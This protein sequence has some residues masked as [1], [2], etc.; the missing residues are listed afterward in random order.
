M[1]SNDVPT[2][3][4]IFSLHTRPRSASASAPGHATNPPDPLPPQP[5]DFL[6]SPAPTYA[7]SPPSIRLNRSDYSSFD[8]GASLFDDAGSGG[9]PRSGGRGRPRAS[10]IDVRPAPERHGS[11]F[12]ERSRE[13]DA[14]E[15]E[16]LG[17]QAVRRRRAMTAFSRRLSFLGSE[18]GNDMSQRLRDPEEARAAEERQR[19]D[20]QVVDLLDVI[21]TPPP[22]RFAT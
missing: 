10:N 3:L 14:S 21:G 9:G 5:N 17:R 11:N 8:D 12:G 22:F 19:H 1:S 7:R 16:S 6:R 4:P 15:P 2:P 20:Q 13:G 18:G